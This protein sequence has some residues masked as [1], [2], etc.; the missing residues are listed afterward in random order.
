MEKTFVMTDYR[1][2]AEETLAELGKK[3]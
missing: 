1:L 2:F 3:Q